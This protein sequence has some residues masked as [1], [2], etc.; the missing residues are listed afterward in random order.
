MNERQYN[1]L[2][3]L[4][5]L[6]AWAV[7]ACA[8]VKLLALYLSPFYREGVRMSAL[9]GFI[10]FM[11]WIPVLI[12]AVISLWILNSSQNMPLK[13]LT[14]LLSSIAIGASLLWALFALYIFIPFV[15]SHI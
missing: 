15:F 8:L 14:W 2:P 12:L 3:F 1:T 13:V 10:F 9:V 6:S 11:G 5:A 4:L 7:L